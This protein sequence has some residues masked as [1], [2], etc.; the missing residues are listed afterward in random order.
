MYLHLTAMV[1]TYS[2]KPAEPNWSRSLPAA[3]GSLDDDNLPKRVL[4]W[5]LTMKKMIGSPLS[6]ANF[7]FST[8]AHYTLSS[9]NLPKDPTSPYQTQ[10]PL[11]PFQSEPKPWTYPYWSANEPTLHEFFALKILRICSSSSRVRAK[12]LKSAGNP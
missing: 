8:S 6:K 5:H 11:W 12:I 1:Y 9:I 10:F 3:L 2:T 7:S 4:V